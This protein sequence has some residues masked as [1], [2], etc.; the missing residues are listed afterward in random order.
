MPTYAYHCTNCS[1]KLEA[2]QK[3]TEEP[4]KKCPSCGKDTLN[5]GPGGGVGLSFKGDGFYIT[6]YG[7]RKDSKDTKDTNSNSCGSC[8]PCGKNTS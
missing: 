7:S 6:D 8:C 4:L 3:I 2:F 5:R 1:H